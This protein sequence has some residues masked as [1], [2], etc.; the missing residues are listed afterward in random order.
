MHSKTGVCL[1]GKSDHPLE[2]KWATSLHS[3]G[4]AKQSHGFLESSRNAGVEPNTL[5]NSI[6]VW[7]VNSVQLQAYVAVLVGYRF[8]QCDTIFF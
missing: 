2:R 1:T 6:I 5:P 8:A 4:I 3:R 7:S